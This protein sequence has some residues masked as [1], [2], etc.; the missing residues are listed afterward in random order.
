MQAAVFMSGGND[1]PDEIYEETGMHTESASV[2]F[3]G[4]AHLS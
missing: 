2:A 3:H 4:K 1:V